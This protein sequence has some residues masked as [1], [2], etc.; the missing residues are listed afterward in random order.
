M[1][2]ENGFAAAPEDHRPL[3]TGFLLI[4]QPLDLI[5]LGGVADPMAVGPRLPCI[6][7]FGRRLPRP[8]RKDILLETA[9][10][11]RGDLMIAVQQHQF[12]D[13]EGVIDLAAGTALPTSSR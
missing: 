7:W 11:F 9:E 10:L 13:A 6:C 3:P 8:F 12:G 5:A 4:R 2:N 1:G